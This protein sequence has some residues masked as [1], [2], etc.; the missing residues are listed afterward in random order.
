MSLIWDLDVLSEL[1]VMYIHEH[2]IANEMPSTKL[3][4]KDITLHY[5]HLTNVFD[6]D[7][8]SRKLAPKVTTLEEIVKS[9]VNKENMTLIGKAK[10]VAAKAIHKDKSRESFPHTSGDLLVKVTLN[11]PLITDSLKV[12]RISEAFLYK[13]TKPS[14][15]MLQLCKMQPKEIYYIG[16]IEQC[17]SLFKY[18]DGECEKLV[19]LPNWV[20]EGSSISLNKEDL[21]IAGG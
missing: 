19:D 13:L 7:E 5:K 10:P 15:E 17:R 8:I 1:C 14:P 9:A 11:H 3:H 18:V 2:I 4:A 20:N 6:S 12:K 21:F 16:Q